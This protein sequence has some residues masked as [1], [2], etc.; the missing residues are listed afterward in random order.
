MA[1]TTSLWQATAPTTTSD[2]WQDGSR[3]DVL[4]V[5]AGITGV[6][7]ALELARRGL[8]VLV[9]EA[10]ELGG[11]TTSRTTGKV[12]LLQGGTLAGIRRRAGAEAVAGYLRANRVGQDWWRERVG[13]GEA[14]QVRDAYTY[15][16]GDRGRRRMVAEHAASVEAGLPVEAVTAA[17][18][19]Y[20]VPAQAV[21]RL[22]DQLQ[23]HPLLALHALVEEARSLGVRLVEGTRVTEVDA[24]HPCIVQT[25]RGVV[26]AGQVVL[27]T[28]TPVLDRGLHFA[29][30]APERSYALSY[31]LPG[32]APPAGMYLSLDPDTR[33]IRSVPVDGEDLL[34]VGGNGHPVG[35]EPHA[36]ARVEGL[37]SWA[38]EVF[39]GAE[40]R[41]L[42]SA[43]D[44]RAEDGVPV[45]GPLSGDDPT[46]LCASGFGKWGMTNAAA[47]ALALVGWV[48]DEVPEWA[49]VYRDRSLAPARL[50]SLASMNATV[51][52]HLAAGWAGGLTSS[53]PDQAPP[54]GCGVVGRDGARLVGCSTVE[55]RTR[56]VSAVCTHLGAALS[57]N[58]AEA[59][60]D[61]PLH[62]SR[63]AADGAVLEG[64]A[65]RPLDPA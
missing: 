35:R 22:R 7:T 25:D 5:G 8:D 57:W 54:E 15:A 32:G 23:T 45:V 29:R 6:A 47:A 21:L 36:R 63:F 3:C 37:E 19:E 65:T 44:Y 41:H 51:A 38:Q 56:S 18:M 62:G 64:P 24:G 1:D 42:W 31:R 33:S 16:V 52:A 9:V 34:V 39:P 60:W 50:G 14:L 2:P 40:R 43:Q 4:V 27:A 11:V 59:S 17:E 58:D 10:R 48:V 20:A 30:L 55:G 49:H 46:I 61:C 26:F 53:L 13:E 28:G 12:S